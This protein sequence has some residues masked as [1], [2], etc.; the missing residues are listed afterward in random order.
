MNRV[1]GVVAVIAV[2]IVVVYLIRLVWRELG[3]IEKL[4]H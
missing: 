3:E 4:R 1:F 2:A